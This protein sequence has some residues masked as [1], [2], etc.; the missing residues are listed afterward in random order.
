MANNRMFVKCKICGAKFMLLKYYPSE[1]WYVYLPDSGADERIKEIDEWL[2][3]HR[4]ENYS[5]WGPT[6][7][8]LVFE[9]ITEEGEKPGIFDDYSEALLRNDIIN[10][11]A[12]GG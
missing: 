3:E 4:H 6:F 2:E 1:G 5:M 10:E 8:E 7:Y 9:Q 12:D 11:G